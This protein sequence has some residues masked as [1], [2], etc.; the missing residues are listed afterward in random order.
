MVDRLVELDVDP[1]EK[2]NDD[3][4]S[5]YSAAQ[6]GCI[7]MVD[8][9]VKLGVD[10]K[11]KSNNGFTSLH[12]ASHNGH[13]A[14]VD[15][16]VELG[17]DPKEKSNDGWTSLHRAAR[18]GHIAMGSRLLDLGV[19]INAQSILGSTAL[20]NAAYFC[21]FDVLESLLQRSPDLSLVDGFGRTVFNWVSDYKPP[22]CMIMKR[23]RTEI[24]ED[25][26]AKRNHLQETIHRLLG[27]LSC[28]TQSYS[29]LGHCL[30][31]LGEEADAITAFEQTII[32][33]CQHSVGCES[34][35]YVII[36]VRYVCKGCPFLNLCEKCVRHD[37]HA[38]KLANPKEHGFL[39]IPSK[40]WHHI[41]QP[42]INGQGETLDSWVKRLTAAFKGVVL[43]SCVKESK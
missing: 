39:E 8:R 35:D 15:R 21:Q 16:L 4:T 5:L 27:S 7:A 42:K 41:E 23:L 31:R 13:V 32:R 2:T 34:C 26:P 6:N 9:L 14:M 38:K 33:D 37:S 30:L 19:D 10:P 25:E 24:Q 20:H 36:G 29:Y 22:A 18:K 40:N 17:V 43:D 28:S 1:K 3:R 12:G 11:E